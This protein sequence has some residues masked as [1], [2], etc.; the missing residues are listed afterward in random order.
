MSLGVGSRLSLLLISKTVAASPALIDVF[1]LG[2]ESQTATLC[3]YHAKGRAQFGKPVSFLQVLGRPEV[4]KKG[5]TKVV[6]HHL[7]CVL[8]VCCA[9]KMLFPGV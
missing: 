5:Q 8:S 2:V 4:C 9:G 3:C 7:P 1:F 6:L